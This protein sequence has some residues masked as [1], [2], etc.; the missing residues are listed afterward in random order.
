MCAESVLYDAKVCRFCGFYFD[1]ELR[2]NLQ[3]R[4]A[5]IE[6]PNKVIDI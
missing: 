2:A 4:V 3:A 1:P 5:A 6:P